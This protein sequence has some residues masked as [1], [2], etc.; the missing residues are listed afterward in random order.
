MYKFYN[1]CHFLNNG[2]DIYLKHEVISE[3]NKIFQLLNLKTKNILN[4]F[5]VFYIVFSNI[6]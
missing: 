3:G 2:D 5:K 1:C 4:S 6:S